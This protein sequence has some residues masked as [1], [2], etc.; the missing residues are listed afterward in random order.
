MDSVPVKTENVTLCLACQSGAGCPSV[1]EIAGQDGRVY[2]LLKC[3][4]CGSGFVYPRPSSKELSAFYAEYFGLCKTNIVDLGDR[5]SIIRSNQAVIEDGVEFLSIILNKTGRKKNYKYLDVGCGHGFSVVAGNSLGLISSGIDLDESSVALGVET[6]GLN[7]TCED[8]QSA[9][10]AKSDLQLVTMWQVLEHIEDFEDGI[11]SVRSALD[12]DGVFAGT[13]PNYSGIYARMRGLKWYMICPPEHLNF[14]SEKGLRACFERNGFE[15]VF[16]GTTLKTAAPLI[17]WGLRSKIES[18]R[19]R[20]HLGDSMAGFIRRMI[21]LGK[22]YLVYL[23]LNALI[24]LFNL[25]GNSTF[26]IVRK[27]SSK[28]S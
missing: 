18:L 3:F 7:L 16:L 4:L 15:V 20:G 6:L 17:Q 5:E 22:R 8:F 14:F 13:V 21:T 28:E 12:S 25:G 1:G 9:L 10:D 19:V 11:K 26:F 24:Y 2:E 23:P 27:K